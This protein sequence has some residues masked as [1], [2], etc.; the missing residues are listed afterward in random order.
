MV[1]IITM[2]FDPAS[3]LVMILAGGEGRRMAP[4]TNERAKPAVP[5]GGRYRIIDIVLSN[6]VNSGLFRIKVLT[7]YKSA[8]LEEHIARVWRLS[9]ILDQYI[10]A[11]PAQQRTGKSWFKGSAD[12]V[13]QCQHVITDEKPPLIAIF[14]GDHVYKMDVR[15]MI[16][17]HV[18]RQCDATIAV[19]PVPKH[20]AREFGVIEV[21]ETGK[22][23]GFHEKVADPPS[24]PGNPDMCLA[25]MGNYVFNT[26]TVMA[27]LNRDAGA[28]E[29]KHDFGHDI[30]PRMVRNGQPVY[31]YDFATNRVPGEDEHGTGYWRDVGTVEAYWQAQM[32]LI[33]IHPHFNLYNDRWPIRT[34]ITHAP[35]AKFVFRDEVHARVG[36][37]TDSLVS[38]GCIISG[39]RIHRSVLSTGCRINSFSE[40]EESVLFENVQ[41]GRHAR[42]RRC[43][44]DK[45]VE[46]PSGAEI[47]FDLELDRKRFHV[48]D[49][50]LVVIPKRAKV[51][52]NGDR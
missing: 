52:E 48:T 15:Q 28:E 45:D 39:G 40:V 35:P 3:V 18:E 43:I 11:I 14:G 10:E 19:I 49:G 27:E 33:E 29:S 7:Q 4:L 50:G 37:A 44:I 12:A 16:A 8:S 21:D 30:L 38:H 36:I 47:G 24:M 42:L 13:Y 20:E 22:I 26:E 5:F 17:F 46:I 1:P 51:E 25:S 41:I 23:V 6:F 34:G 32:D 31:A 9:P 2:N